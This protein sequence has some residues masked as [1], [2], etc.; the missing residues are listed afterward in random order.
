MT[1]FALCI[2]PL[3]VTLD[4]KLT[5]IRIGTRGIKT[6]VMAYADDITIIKTKPE[7][8]AILQETQHDYAETTGATVNIQE[9]KPLALGMWDKSRPILD[10]QYCEEITILVFHMK[11]TTKASTSKSWELLT[12][13]RANAQVEYL[14]GMSMDYRIR[15]VHKYLLARLWYTTQIYPPPDA[16]LRHLKTTISWILWQGVIFRVPLSTLR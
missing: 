1:L 11:K 10:I 15:Y 8:I 13:I 6:R 9:S 2:N 4:K 16:I 7:D 14:R 5:G 3:L 12:R